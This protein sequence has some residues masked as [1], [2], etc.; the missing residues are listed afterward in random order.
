MRWYAPAY[1]LVLIA[2]QEINPPFFLCP[3]DKNRI[4]RYNTFKIEFPG[5]QDPGKFKKERG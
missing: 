2:F 1:S 3:L 4:S 5:S